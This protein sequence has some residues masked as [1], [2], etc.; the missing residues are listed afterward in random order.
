MNLRDCLQDIYEQNGRLTPAIVV[1]AAR[2]KDHPLHNRFEWDDALAG[3]AWRKQQAHELIRSVR[4]TYKDATDQEKDVRAFHAIRSDEDDEFIYEPVEKVI[5]SPMLTQI[6][7][8]DME[9]EWKQLKRR[10]E[11]FKEFWNLVR[12]DS[13][14]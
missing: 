5:E 10:Y 13:A 6:L 4:W 8:R 11:G 12:A 14:A 3:E 1:D 9:R 2:D 7:L